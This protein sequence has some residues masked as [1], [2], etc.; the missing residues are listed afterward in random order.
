MINIYMDKLDNWDYSS[1]QEPP[2]PPTPAFA[3]TEDLSGPIGPYNTE[4]YPTE[5]FS[6]PDNKNMN[7][8]IS[9]SVLRINEIN[10]ERQ[11]AYNAALKKYKSVVDR[12][13][14]KRGN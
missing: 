8:N 14:K 11:A 5:S 13:A 7:P 4:F 2:V 6:R 12:L 9:E 1:A 3:S 10:N